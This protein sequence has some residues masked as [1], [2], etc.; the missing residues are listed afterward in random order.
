[1]AAQAVGSPVVLP[2]Q[3]TALGHTKECLQRAYDRLNAPPLSDLDFVLSDLSF[4]FT[5]R[6]TE[7][8][9][10]VSGRMLGALNSAGVMLGEDSAMLARMCAAMGQYQ[11]PDGHFGADQNMAAGIK[12]EREMPILWGNGRLLLALVQRYQQA[13]EP[14]VLKMARGI[15]DY[16]VATRQYLGKPENLQLGGVHAAGYTTCYPSTIEGLVLLSEVTQDKKYLEEARFIAGIALMDKVFEKHH[17]HGRLAAYRGMLEIDRV[18]GNDE[19]LPSVKAG[20][21]KIE[22]ELLLPTGGVNESF[23]RT[24]P[25]DEGCSE[26]D[27]IMTNVLLWR[28]TGERKYLDMAEFATRNHL[29]A[30]QFSNG[31]FGHH[32][33]RTLSLGDTKYL[34]GGFEDS[35]AEAY[36]C[37]SMH[38]AQMLGDLPRFA[39]VDDNQAVMVTW[40]AE[41]QAKLRVQNQP[42]SVVVTQTAVNTW[43]VQLETNGNTEFPLRLRV[44][45]W[46]AGLIVNNAPVEERGGWAEVPVKANDSLKLEVRFPVDVHPLGVYAERPAAHEPQRLVA[47]PDLY[48]LPDVAIPEGF[49]PADAVPSVILAAKVAD[50]DGIPVVVEG[51]KDGTDVV[52][53]KLVRMMDRPAGG[54]RWLFNVKRVAESEL[55]KAQVHVPV[56]VP[57]EWVLACDGDC[58]VFLNGKSVGTRSG[59]GE[60]RRAEV[61]VD[62]GPCVLAIKAKSKA[63]RPA[64]IGWVKIAENLVVTD[65]SDRWTA[66]RCPAQ[67]PAAWLTDVK[68]GA[69]QAVKLAEFGGFGDGPWKHLAAEPAGTPARWIWPDT[70]GA[71]ADQCWLVRCVLQIP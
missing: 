45:S 28:A 61:Y 4:K 68:Q 12:P 14:D 48:C 36:W 18:S 63:A 71:P 29:L 15:G 20:V 57:I 69:D 21:D 67:V 7:Y 10:D 1:M 56:G 39:V 3:V 40:L 65:T 22:A 2:E 33:L 49:I 11:K 8:S 62:R 6:F 17:S 47:G 19:F 32:T 55:P 53:T 30:C 16:V 13:K 24:D 52:A 54:C 66:V 37:C 5:R 26:V 51:G 23:G 43:N 34:G 58:E 27:W 31:G 60:N 35:G 9:G 38:G 46:A 42:V 25:R 59:W 44:P 64:M 41:V 50:K 70:T